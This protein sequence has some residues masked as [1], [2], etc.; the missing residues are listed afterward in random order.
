MTDE[1]PQ[2]DGTAENTSL[3][4]HLASIRQSR[5]HSLRKVE[6]LT[7]KEVSNAYLSQIES[8][9]I[10]KPSPK[11]L[12]TLSKVYRVSY[13]HLMKLAGHAIPD[14]RAKRFAG[15]GA[16]FAELDLTEEEERELLAYLQ[17]RRQM[18]QKSE[19]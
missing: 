9:K 5:G 17:F 10:E 14:S 1:S 13:E 6:E 12:Y 15:R 11:I 3:G 18:K 4:V 19:A 16:T 8:G 7:G 2:N